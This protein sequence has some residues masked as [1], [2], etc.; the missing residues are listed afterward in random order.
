[1]LRASVGVARLPQFLITP[2]LA[3]GRLVHWGDVPGPVGS[4]APRK[5]QCDRRA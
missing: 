5:R 2:D 1:M 3:V 4:D